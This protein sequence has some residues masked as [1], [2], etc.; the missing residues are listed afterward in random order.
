MFRLFMSSAV[1]WPHIAAQDLWSSVQMPSHLFSP[2]LC[3][4]ESVVLIR[5]QTHIT[6]TVRRNVNVPMCM[7]ECVN[8][9]ERYKGSYI[10]RLVAHLSPVPIQPSPKLPHLDPFVT[11]NSHEREK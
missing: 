10:A 8:V 1:S 11:E 4:E 3:A 9:C 6:G 7:C 2:S 5:R